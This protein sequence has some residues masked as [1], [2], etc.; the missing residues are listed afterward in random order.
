MSVIEELLELAERTDAMLE[1]PRVRRAYVPE[2]DIDADKD[3]EFGL[4]ELEDGAVGLFYAWLGASQAGMS[5]IYPSAKL[6]GLR[7]IRLARYLGEDNDI[8]RSIGL[9]AMN[10]ITHSLF[11]RANFMPPDA[12]NS[13]G[14]F[15]L[16]A[17]DHLGMIGNFPS[18]VR[19]ARNDGIPITVIE[20]KS[21]MLGQSEQVNITSDPNA[22]KTCNK[23]ICTA[24]TLINDSVDEMLT[25][26]RDAEQAAMIGPSAG[27]FP[28]PLFARGIGVLGGSEIRDARA[29]VDGQRSGMGLRNCSRRY[30]L[31]QSDY[32]GFENLL[33]RA[34]DGT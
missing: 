33:Q 4:L 18:L 25:Y 11:K 12:R 34:A 20:R 28:E 19:Q 6:N 3:A 29:A 32:P 9:A 16:V 30:T 21:H 2:P 17:G 14:G 7:P 24:A 10:A 1:L 8:A 13:R 27:F 26:C 22:L 31:S 5:T 23:I 15:E